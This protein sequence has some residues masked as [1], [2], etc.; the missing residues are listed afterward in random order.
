MNLNI[1]ASAL[2]R[3]FADTFRTVFLKKDGTFIL[4]AADRPSFI[5][6]TSEG[7]GLIQ[8]RLSQLFTCAD[9]IISLEFRNVAYR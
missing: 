2:S 1:I 9:V 6:S 8:E 5:V 7:Y 3:G 4:F